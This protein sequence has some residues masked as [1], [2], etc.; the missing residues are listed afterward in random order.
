MVLTGRTALLAV[1]CA[2]VVAVAAPSATGVAVATGVVV[3]AAVVDAVLAGSPRSL[4]VERDGE[5]AVRLGEPATVRVRVRNDG[6]RRL[7]G[8]IRD[9]WPPSAGA[10]DERSGLDLPPGA[11]TQVRTTLVPTRRGDRHADRVT[12]RS[13]GPLRLGGRQSWHAA[14]WTVRALPPFRARRHLPALLTRLH[15][16]D[17]RSAIRVRGAGTEFDSLREYVIG[18]DTRSI[19]WRATARR[20]DVVVRTWRPERDR[21]VLIVLDTGRTSAGRVGDAPRLDAAMDAALLLA[22][23]ANHA[24]DRVDM[25]AYD[26]QVRASVTRPPAGATL[27]RM[28]DALA[29]VEPELVETDHRG[30]SAEIMRRAGRHA[31]VVVLTGLDSAAVE[32]GLL[33]VIGRLTHRHTLLVASVGDPRLE[34]MAA[35]RGDAAAVYGAAAAEHDRL[36]RART[37]WQLTRRGAHVV[38]AAPDSLPPAVADAYLQLKAAGRL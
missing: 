26:R 9:A 23:M 5:H 33:P 16:I 1:L 36:A 13:I 6:G 29:T 35:G 14:P 34:A 21:H 25:V 28:V 11:G 20:G 17:G 15:E 3:V 19:D 27:P 4:R 22:A 8:T 7:R 32:L 2:V 37:S 24:G 31:F 38:D 12:V 10:T 30:L 18:D